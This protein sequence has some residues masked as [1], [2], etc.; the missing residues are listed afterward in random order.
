MVNYY[1]KCNLAPLYRLLQK[2]T[3]WKWGIQER[4]AFETVKEQLTKSPV[5][6]HYDPSKPLTMAWR[7]MLHRTEWEQCYLTYKKMVQRNRLH[8]F[9]SR[10]LNKVEQRYSQLDKEALAMGGNFYRV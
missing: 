6:E 10:T 9:A 2:K 3:Q 5:L 4:K 1:G 7:L 8:A